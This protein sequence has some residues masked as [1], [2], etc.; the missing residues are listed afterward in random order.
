MS[1]NYYKVLHNFKPYKNHNIKLMK[2]NNIIKI[3]IHA[4][5]KPLE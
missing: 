4:K 5:M 3:E 2:M 1:S